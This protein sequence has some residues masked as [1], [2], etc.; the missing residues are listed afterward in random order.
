MSGAKAIS[1]NSR[2]WHLTFSLE[3]SSAEASER[4][5][6]LFTISSCLSK[7]PGAIWTTLHR[8]FMDTSMGCL[9]GTWL[10]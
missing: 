2:H 3:M 10:C 8:C 5:M 7:S 4:S 1:Q 6:V 9:F